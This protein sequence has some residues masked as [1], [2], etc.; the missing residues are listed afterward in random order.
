VL[1]N[2]RTY[3]DLN[4]EEGWP[5]IHD[6]ILEGRSVEIWIATREENPKLWEAAGAYHQE[7]IERRER[8][9]LKG[10]DGVPIPSAP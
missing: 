3:D 2:R 4:A 5:P 10:P 9:L 1:P 7:A 8:E 6:P